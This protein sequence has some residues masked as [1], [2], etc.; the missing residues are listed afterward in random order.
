M[1]FGLLVTAVEGHAS[2]IMPPARNS[3][4]ANLPAW[5][6]GK[7]P[8]T[9][10][11]DRKAAPCTNGTSVCD[12]GQSTFWFSQGCTIG[13]ARCDGNGSRVANFDHCPG[14]SIK[15]T[16]LPRYRT[17]N[18]RALP[19]SPQDVFKFNPWMAPGLA[20]TYDPCGMAGGAPVPTTAAA[21]YNPTK[22][23]KQGDLGSVVLAPRPS[24]TVWTRGTVAYVRQQ[25]TAPHGGGYVYR[26]C[27]AGENLT[28]ACFNR[29]QL[30]FATP[31]THML[32]FADPALDRE[33]NATMVTEG[34]GKG[35]MVYPWPSGSCPGGVCSGDCMYVVGPGKHCYYRNGTRDN[36]AGPPV[37]GKPYCPGCGA[38]LYGSDGACPC[39]GPHT[40]PDVPRDAGS[41]LAFTPDPAPGHAAS[42]YAVEDGLHVPAGITPGEYV[43]GYRWDAEMT[44]Q[45]WSSCADITIE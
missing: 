4:D 25:S 10:T 42:T 40:C 26:L 32:R 15:P 23:A 43:L 24:G 35:W 2:M 37:P 13:C 21:E 38:P 14:R 11:I 8:P 6:G 39:L 20:P 17:A 36:G 34:G 22:Y 27:P 28:E 1:A 16:L 31:G 7:H 18:R 41:D 29:L 30:A 9:G 3:V 44:S 45:V 12:S 5:S 19:G 33:V